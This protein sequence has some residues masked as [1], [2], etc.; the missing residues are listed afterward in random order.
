MTVRVLYLAEQKAAFAALVDFFEQHKAAL[1]P[2]K[3]KYVVKM[4]VGDMTTLENMETHHQL[5]VYMTPGSSP[6]LDLWHTGK[7]GNAPPHY[8]K[9]DASI[10]EAIAWLNPTAKK[11]H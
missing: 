6:R 4:E 3:N 9:A 8:R 10:A 5:L 2:F 1:E 11:V 7:A